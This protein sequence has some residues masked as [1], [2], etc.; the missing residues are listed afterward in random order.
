M[1]ILGQYKRPHFHYRLPSER[2]Q[3]L[4]SDVHEAILAYPIEYH[5]IDSTPVV[6]CQGVVY[7][8]S[9]NWATGGCSYEPSHPIKFEDLDWWIF[10]PFD[11]LPSP[12]MYWNAHAQ[13]RCEL[14]Q[15]EIPNLNTIHIDSF[16]CEVLINCSSLPSMLIWHPQNR[17][18]PG[19]NIHVEYMYGNTL[20]DCHQLSLGLFW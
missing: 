2:P 10:P 6:E 12:L 4:S 17:D 15:M 13:S 3:C 8:A 9:K 11:I 16:T 7:Y 14:Q 5:G 19:F 20:R 18:T 1:L